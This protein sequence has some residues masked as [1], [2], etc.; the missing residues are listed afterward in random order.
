MALIHLMAAVQDTNLINRGGLEGQHW[1]AQQAQTILKKPI[2][3]ETI[4][5]FDQ[6]MIARNLSPGGCADLLAVA[7]FLYLLSSLER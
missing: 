7:Y 3:M 2:T 5:N 1:T 6:N 4:A